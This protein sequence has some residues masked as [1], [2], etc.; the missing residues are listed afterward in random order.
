MKRILFVIFLIAE[1]L[2]FYA[3]GNNELFIQSIK[4]QD[5]SS[6]LQYADNAASCLRFLGNNQISW[7]EYVSLM[8]YA[9]EINHPFR[10]SLI[11][12]GV[13][14]LGNCAIKYTEIQSYEM[15]ISLLETALS[16]TNFVFTQD[17]ILQAGL[18][19]Q[20]AVNNGQLAKYNEAIKHSTIAYEIAGKC[21]N[22]T[23]ILISMLNDIGFF[24]WQATN[25]EAAN[26]YLQHA[27]DLSFSLPSNH[28]ERIKTVYYIANSFSEMGLLDA[29]YKKIDNCISSIG[30]TDYAYLPPLLSSLAKICVDLGK[31]DLAVEYGEKGLSILSEYGTIS[32]QKEKDE[33]S[34]L[35]H[36]SMAYFYL[37]N[38][39]KAIEY[40]ERAFSIYTP[41]D[42]N[43]YAMFLNN[44]GALYSNSN[45]QKSLECYNKAI[46]L[47]SPSNNNYLLLLSNVGNL[48]FKIKNPTIYCRAFIR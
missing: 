41:T 42:S 22:D 24:Y 16:L 38:T 1:S 21:T 30:P 45:V 3:F 32:L 26:N 28:K 44:L 25:Y 47:I 5:Y 12:N 40:A 20:L 39:E 10:D 14:F 43:E 11:I 37:Y 4:Q 18:H 6:C 17:N 36:L 2:S 8:S 29:A 19:K 35:N 34:L 13:I 23:V 48:Y 15:A 33:S 7:D 31:Y 46:S 9:D 27:E